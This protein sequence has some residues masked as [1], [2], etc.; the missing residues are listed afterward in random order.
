MSEADARTTL[1]VVVTVSGAAAI[2]VATAGIDPAQL[3]V[4]KNDRVFEVGE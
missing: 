4:D 2:I 1:G 3:F